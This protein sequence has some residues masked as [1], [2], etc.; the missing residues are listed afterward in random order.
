MSTKGNET[1]KVN[2]WDEQKWKQVR[3]MK[4]GSEINQEK[5]KTECIIALVC[6]QVISRQ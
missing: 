1:K 4:T 2:N 6:E 5:E 3:K